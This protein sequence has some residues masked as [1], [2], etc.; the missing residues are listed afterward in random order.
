M[1]ITQKYISKSQDW[2]ESNDD[3]NGL[4][5]SKTGIGIKETHLYLKKKFDKPRQF[6]YYNLYLAV[7][8]A[9]ITNTVGWSFIV[10]QR[11]LRAKKMQVMSAMFFST[12]RKDWTQKTPRAMVTEA[13]GIFLGCRV[14]PSTSKGW[15]IHPPVKL[16]TFSPT[17]KHSRERV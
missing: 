17:S 11:P 16:S 3:R 2:R 14:T 1:K 4:G 15:P 5:L 10:S 6:P 7:T 12:F 9:S 8:A 13:T